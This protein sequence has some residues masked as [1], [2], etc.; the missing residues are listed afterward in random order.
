MLK[1][2]IYT[3]PTCV[4]CKMTKE[5]FGEHNIQYAEK[6]VVQDEEARNEMVTKSG[7]MGVPVI[8]IDGEIIVG[9]DEERLGE[10][11]KIK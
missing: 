5:F 7:Q 4:Y 2:T 3:T 1:V 9:F 10:L 8:D 6:N 11:L